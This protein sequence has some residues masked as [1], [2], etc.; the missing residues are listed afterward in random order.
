MIALKQ[1][2]QKGGNADAG[3]H[4]PKGCQNRS[5][6]TGY[7]YADKCGCIYSQGPGVIWDMVM[8]SV[9]VFWETHANRSTTCSCMS[10]M[11]A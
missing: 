10:G 8:I 6:Y 9:N 5:R 11:M 2:V 3:N 4:A 7:L 1:P